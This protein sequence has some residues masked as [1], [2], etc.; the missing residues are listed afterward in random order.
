[1]K[2]RSK[3]LSFRSPA[4]RPPSLQTDEVFLLLF[5]HKKKILPSPAPWSVIVGGGIAGDV[6]HAIKQRARA[7][8]ALLSA[9]IML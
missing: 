3:K 8:A 9:R 6:N 5:V 1:L 2:K 4:S 7:W